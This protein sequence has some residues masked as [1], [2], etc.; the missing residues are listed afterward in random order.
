MLRTHVESVRLLVASSCKAN[1]CTHFL[2]ETSL[3]VAAAVAPAAV[4]K[5]PASFVDKPIWAIKESH[6]VPA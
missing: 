5:G 1:L 3:Q 2:V 6:W 4:G